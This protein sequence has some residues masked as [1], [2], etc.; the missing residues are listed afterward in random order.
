LAAPAWLGLHADNSSSMGWLP[1]NGPLQ[2]NGCIRLVPAVP[3]ESLADRDLHP[4]RHASPGIPDRMRPREAPAAPALP[5][6]RACGVKPGRVGSTG[7]PA[8]L[9]LY[10]PE[11][12]QRIARRV[13]SGPGGN[14]EDGDD[15]GAAAR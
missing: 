1:F 8:C 13:M 5:H 9:H 12:M 14:D 7:R 11:A 15:H 6:R 2:E 3:T 4:S 10:I